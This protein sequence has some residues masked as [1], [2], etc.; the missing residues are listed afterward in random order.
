[1][2]C[3]ILQSKHLLF[4]LLHFGSFFCSNL[5][6]SLVHFWFFKMPEIICD[7][8][9]YLFKNSFHH[10]SALLN[11]VTDWLSALL[12]ARSSFI[13]FYLFSILRAHESDSN[14]S[15]PSYFSVLRFLL[16]N[17]EVNR[18]ARSGSKTQRWF[19]LF[20]ATHSYRF[21]KSIWVYYY[22]SWEELPKSFI[23]SIRPVDICILD[24]KNRIASFW[25]ISMERPLWV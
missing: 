21:T 10:R 6:C 14:I 18:T 4:L 22:Y 20:K 16:W 23:I 5:Y 2:G 13:C 24:S 15:I 1:M 17:G 9:L 12:T 7:S 3:N 11:L 25:P 8:K 19:W